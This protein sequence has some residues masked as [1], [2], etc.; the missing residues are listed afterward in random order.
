M[1]PRVTV[2]IP[3]Y[4]R[5]QYL[6]QCVSSLLA[7]TLTDFELIISDNCSTDGTS[8]MV[9]QLADPRIRYYRNASNIGV[10]Q[11]MNRCLELAT[12][13]YVSILH[14]DDLYAPRF[15][16]RETAILDL[17]QTVGL[18]HCAAYQIDADGIR[19]RVVRA[20]QRDCVVEGKKEFISYLSG[21]NI[22]CSTAMVRRSLYL[23]VEPFD[24]G[25]MCADWLMW[26]QLTLLGDVAY[27]SEPLA[28]MRV[29]GSAL[30]CGIEPSRWCQDFLAILDRGCQ[31]ANSTHPSLLPTKTGAC[32]KAINAQGK[33]FLIAAMAAITSGA[34]SI[35]D[36]Y[37][38]V[39]RVLEARGLSRSYRLLT[40]ALRNRAGQRLLVYARRFRRAR[41]ARKVS[42]E[43]G[44]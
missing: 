41:A 26:L 32:H 18:V 6:A 30:S 36:G 42:A 13:D 16:E 7:Q 25:Y 12:G 10:F 17:H 9:R 31:L 8:D 2:C 35:T 14:D 40:G 4:N 39:F 21:H 43:A 20:Y 3:T 1:G 23:K 33:R 19:Q 44:W 15:L 34:F 24:A 37:V 27:I 22:C 28:A 5:S 11:N 29:H 38:Q